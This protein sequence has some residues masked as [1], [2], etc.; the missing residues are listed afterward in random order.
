MENRITIDPN[1]CHGKPTIRHSRLLVT[2]VLEL[3]AAGTTY[4]EL[5]E[6]YPGLEIADIQTCLSFAAQII[7]F[8]AMTVTA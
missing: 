4:E 2:T 8:R 5:I 7:N 6:D 1:V 3:L